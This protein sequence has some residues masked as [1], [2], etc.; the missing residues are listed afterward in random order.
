MYAKNKRKI[1][2]EFEL[3]LKMNSADNSGDIKALQKALN[4]AIK[5]ELT[6]KQSEILNMY[7]YENLNMTQ[8]AAIYN[9]NKST[10]SR[11]I[12]NATEKL[13]KTLKYAEFALKHRIK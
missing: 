2:P 5:T 3:F 4:R 8:I 13:H 1:H 6:L 12:K 10:I 9:V 7:F 11:H